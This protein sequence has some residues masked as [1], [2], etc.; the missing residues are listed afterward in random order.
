MQRIGFRIAV[1]VDP[2]AGEPGGQ[3]RV[4]AF[5]ADRQRQLEVRHHDADRL[6]RGVHYPSRDHVRW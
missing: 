5:P 1:D 3:T 2:P 4:L 6:R